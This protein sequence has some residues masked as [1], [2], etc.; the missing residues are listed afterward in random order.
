M[1][2]SKIR[3]QGSSYVVTIPRE[4]ME[5]YHLKKG[6]TI[7]F[8]PVLTEIQ[9]HYALEP[10]LEQLAHEVFDEFKDAFVYLA[11]C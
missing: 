6:D 9:T 7:A 4:A 8:S 2:T 1:I 3:K 10:G 11:D 5:K